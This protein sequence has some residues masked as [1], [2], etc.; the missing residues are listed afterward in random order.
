V[1]RRGDV[2]VAQQV[3]RLVVGAVACHMPDRALQARQRASNPIMA[4][5][6]QFE[7]LV[8]ARRRSVHAG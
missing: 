4:T 3:A 5:G 1:R 2:E 7:R 6:E 8:K